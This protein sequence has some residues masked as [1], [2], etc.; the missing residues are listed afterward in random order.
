M[1]LEATRALYAYHHHAMGHLLTVTAEVPP[2]DLAREVV[3]GQ[4]SLI[5]SAH[6]RDAAS[7]PGLV[8]RHAAG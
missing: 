4:P 3:P 6:V 1:M 8:E 5:Q 7:P 2:A